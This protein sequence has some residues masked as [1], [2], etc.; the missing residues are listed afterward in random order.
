MLDCKREGTYC[1]LNTT[2]IVKENGTRI[3]RVQRNALSAVS[4][5]YLIKDL[6]IEIES[7]SRSIGCGKLSN[8][9]F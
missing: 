2:L 3:S 1:L 9:Q 8:I 5:E 7:R 4:V 6:K